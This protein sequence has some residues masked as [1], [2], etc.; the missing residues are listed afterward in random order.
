MLES[1]RMKG[2]VERPVERR[3]EKGGATD[4]IAVEEPLEI[5]I[6]GE[7]IAVTM[8]TPGD[9]SRLALGF[10]FAEGI[11]ASRDDVGSIAHCGRPDEEGYGNVLEVKS[12][13]GV[14]IDVER[15]L[16][17]RNFTVTSACG[18]CGR[19]SIDD[20]LARCLPI[21][22]DARFTVAQIERSMERLRQ[23][24]RNFALTGGLH[25][26][27][28]FDEEGALIA[29]YEDIGRHNAVDKTVGTLL[30]ERKIGAAALLVVSGRSSFEIVQKAAAAR[31]PVVASV[32]APSS[33]AIDV[34]KS[35]G[36]TL[37]GFV[38]SPSL[39]VYTHPRRI[40]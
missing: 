28:T 26:A 24:Q 34:A 9:D 15:I 12:A 10:L 30:F 14:P 5:R 8:R 17:G 38:R 13:P 40:V 3:P 6:D 37:I 18:V 33:L 25:A 1:K 19:K 4:S 22:S 39:N 27:A 36:I 23:D 21:A 29:S 31:I 7:T 35:V 2:V 20:L 32:S 11:I 16:A